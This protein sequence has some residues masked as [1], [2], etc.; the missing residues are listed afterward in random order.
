MEI[1]V[2]RNGM[3]FGKAWVADEGARLHFRARCPFIPG[4][5]RLYIQEGNGDTLPLGVL[6]PEGGDLTLD[7]TVNRPRHAFP[8]LDFFQY[9]ILC[10]GDTQPEPVK[11]EAL[12]ETMPEPPQTEP[13]ARLDRGLETPRPVSFTEYVVLRAT[14]AGAQGVLYRYRTGC[15][16][17]AIPAAEHAHIAPALLFAR[18]EEIRGA[19]YYVLKLSPEGL[20]RQADAPST[21]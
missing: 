5:H 14:L 19:A 12:P 15:I 16:E 13:Y 2:Y 20:P 4:I 11:R 6:M 1:V 17:L 18:A 3:E 21:Y 8:G 7:R 9:G 10:E